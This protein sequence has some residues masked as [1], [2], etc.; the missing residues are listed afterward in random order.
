MMPIPKSLETSASKSGHGN[1]FG[2]RYR[3]LSRFSMANHTDQLSGVVPLNHQQLGVMG[4]VFKLANGLFKRVFRGELQMH[5]E[6]DII[7]NDQMTT[8][9]IEKCIGNIGE[10]DH[11]HHFFLIINQG[12]SIIGGTAQGFQDLVERS[13]IRYHCPIPPHDMAAPKTC[14]LFPS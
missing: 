7:G 9:G 5:S 12:Q 8:A 1:C 6:G 13:T 2:F 11:S 4:I 14:R 3:F 10:F